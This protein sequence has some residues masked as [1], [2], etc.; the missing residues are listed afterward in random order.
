[1]V[2]GGPFLVNTGKW[3]ARAANE[4]YFVREASTEDK[5]DWGEYNRP[6]SPEKFN[7]ILARLQA[8]LQ[9]EE[10]FVQDVYVGA[11]PN[12]RMPI[13]IITDKAWQSLFARNMFITPTSRDELKRFVPEFTL[14]ASPSF[15]VDPRLDG[16]RS[17]TA[18]V[19]DFSKRL[20]IVANSSY[21]GEVKKTISWHSEMLSDFTRSIKYEGYEGLLSDFD[22]NITRIHNS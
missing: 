2:H 9:G 12:F 1:M 13:R 17:E 20:A 8:F 21:G 18:I 7:G 6:I 11:D 19:V 22:I 10:L 14:I 16:T 3:T 15:N 4:K 5:I